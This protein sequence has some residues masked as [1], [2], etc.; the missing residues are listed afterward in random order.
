[1]QIEIQPDAPKFKCSQCG[2][3][4]SIIR[5]NMSSSDLKFLEEHA[6]GVLPVVQLN[7]TGKTSFPLYDW[8]AKRFMQW[9]KEANIDAKIMPSKAILDLNSNKAI[10]VS[11]HMDY[12]SCPFL[13]NNKCSIYY[14]KRAYVCRMFPFNGSHFLNMEEAKIKKEGIFGE[15]GGMKGIMPLIPDEADKMT[16]FFTDAFPDGPFINAV[17]N[18]IVIEW[19]NK[20]IIDLIKSKKIRAAVNYPYEFL[21]KR[22]NSSE[23]VDFTDFLLEIEYLD[24]PKLKEI[25]QRFDGNEDALEKIKT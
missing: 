20:T 9:Q 25:I 4:C 13:K 12:D 14:T 22:M 5:G 11:Y 2:K 24:E 17:Q 6:Y 10:I 21:I 3:C 19:I 7:P 23:K 18:D 8:E 16:G 15:C 1:M